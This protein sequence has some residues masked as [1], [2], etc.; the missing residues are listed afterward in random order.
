M[1][2]VREFWRQTHGVTLESHLDHL[3]ESL[4]GSLEDFRAQSTL[5]AYSYPWK[6]FKEWCQL[7]GL[8]CLPATAMTLALFLESVKLQ[9]QSPAS[10]ELSRTSVNFV[11][12]LCGLEEPGSSF[13]CDVVVQTTRRTLGKPVSKAKPM[14]VD[15]VRRVVESFHA[16]ERLSEL[17]ALVGLVVGFAAFARYSDLVNIDLSVSR[18]TETHMELF[19]VKRKTLQELTGDWVLV[20]RGAHPPFCPVFLLQQLMVAGSVHEGTFLRASVRTKNGQWLG[21]KV[22]SYN[23]FVAH[24]RQLLVGVGLSESEAKEY[25]AHSLRRGGVTTAAN[26]GVADRLTMA[27]GGWHSSLVHSGYIQS[28]LNDLLAPSRALGF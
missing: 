24:F 26:N 15:L 18:F 8:V 9:K 2:D 25:T 7:E 19:F 20:A 21:T 16:T 27:H 28:K 11:H 23:T 3:F 5:R 1:S 17:V 13:V 6:A 4:L 12:R 10:V 22:L 14:D